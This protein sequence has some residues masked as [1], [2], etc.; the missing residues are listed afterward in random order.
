MNPTN[1][2]TNAPRFS[3]SWDDYFVLVLIGIMVGLG[4]LLFIERPK[5][6]PNMHSPKMAW[7]RAGLYFSFV[8]VF[9]SVT[10]VLKTILHS[11]LATAAQIENPAWLALTALCVGL[12]IWGYVIWWPRGTL[13]YDR[14]LYFVPQL[15]FG[16]TWGV[17]SGLF[18]LAVWSVL[19]QFQFPAIVTAVLMLVIIAV[20]NMNYQSGWW[21]IHVSPPHNIRAWN[22][23]KVLFAHN[24]FL[25]ASLTYLVLYGNIGLF[26]I[27]NMLALGASAVAMRFPPFWEE[28]GGPVSL[29]TAIGE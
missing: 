24:P 1:Y 26:V 15:L 20:Y 3:G 28:D 10:G 17:C 29:E 18:F 19:E 16:L 22:N 2:F 5:H 6:D 27:L 23:K 21:D 11:P 8:I 4:V 9:S 25:L 14:K 13:T 12:V 7:L